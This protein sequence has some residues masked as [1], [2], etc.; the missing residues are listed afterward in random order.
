[1]K[2]TALQVA[3][4]LGARAVDVKLTQPVTIFA[5]KNFAGKSSLQEAIRMALTGDTVRVSLK[6]DYGQLISEGA[7]SGFAEVEI[8]GQRRA[9]VTLPDGKA[10]PAAEYVA[11]AALPYVLDAQRFAR[12]DPND[13]STFLFGLMGVQ[14]SGDAVKQ[15]L[16]AKGCDQKLVDAVMPL[17][18]AGFDAAHKEAQA[19]A[20]DAKAS[21]RTVTGET[22]GEKK[23]EVWKAAGA[24][25][26]PAKPALTADD[27]AE[28]D[29]QIAELNTEI[30]AAQGRATAQAKQ[31]E[32]LA[33]TRAKVVRGVVIST[34][35]IPVANWVQEVRAEIGVLAREA[36]ASTDVLQDFL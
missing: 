36:G 13:R 27:L 5:G 33:A 17:L 31:A 32:Q 6:K 14:S 18:R 15:R 16:L 1:M 2:I 8:D 35:T 4:F 21:W 9:Y 12:L 25:A 19:K 30:G 7:T 22:Y 23:A 24:A 34:A 20:R 26:A 3:N 29:R 11:P 28:M 10:T